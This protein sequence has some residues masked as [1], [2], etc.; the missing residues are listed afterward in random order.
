M[1]LHFKCS[2]TNLST[3]EPVLDL[4]P[5]A[6]LTNQRSHPELFGSLPFTSHYSSS[7]KTV[8]PVSP[9]AALRVTRNQLGPSPPCFFLLLSLFFHSSHL[10][11][12]FFSLTAISSL[13]VF[14]S[15]FLS[16]LMSFLPQV[17]VRLINLVFQMSLML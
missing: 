14:P 16:F 10:V 9:S 6:A 17:C 7:T 1:L 12:P 2:K 8:V 3:G 15:Y 13:A 11:P 5:W 4:P